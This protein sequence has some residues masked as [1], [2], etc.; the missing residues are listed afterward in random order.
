VPFTAATLYDPMTAHAGQLAR[1]STAGGAQVYLQLE[2]G[3]TMVLRADAGTSPPA[4]WTYFKPT[5]QPVILG[6]EWSVEFIDGGPALP[7]AYKTSQLASWTNAPDAKTR[8]FAGT[9]RYTLRFTA[10]RERADDWLLD[11]GDVRESARVRLNGQ[12]ITAL[13]AI[14]FRTRVGAH[15][16]AG[17]NTLEIEVTNLTAN[18]IRDLDLR[19]VDWRVMKDA[20]I[21]NVLYKEF[22]PAQWPIEDSGLLGPVRLLP[23][24]RFSPAP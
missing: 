24:A 2:A 9:G 11:L 13:I 17:V 14:P 12:E 21:V 18:R 10:P 15:L 22:L 20:N 1:R 4:A 5:G 19:Q 6:G 7:A 23:L 8:A 3:E 16:K